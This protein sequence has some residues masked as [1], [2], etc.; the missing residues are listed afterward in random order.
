MA[1]EKL[2]RARWVG[3][4]TGELSQG[5]T[6]QPGDEHPDGVT[7]ADLESAHWEAVKASAPKPKDE[8]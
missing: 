4:F 5:V 6:L 7:A 3:P 1:D 2:H 8:D